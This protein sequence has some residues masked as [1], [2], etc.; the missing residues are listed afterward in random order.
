MLTRKFHRFKFGTHRRNFIEI[1]NTHYKI[2]GTPNSPVLLFSNSLGTDM[3]MW[4]EVVP[5]LL[6]YFQIVRY[7]TRGLGKSDVTD[8]P[9]TIAQLGQD[10]IDLIDLLGIDKIHFCGLSMGGQI[11]QWLGIHHSHRI[12]KLV[13]SNTGAKIGSAQGWNDR[14]ELINQK[15]LSAIWEGTKNVWFRDVFLKHNP[16]K[17]GVL[18]KMFLH[19]EVVGYA[20]CCAAVR[21][22]DFRSDIEKIKPE[23]LVITGHED[24]ATTVADAEFIV[25]KIP[26]A[27]LV[28]LAAKHIPSIEQPKLFAEAVINFLVGAT[29]QERGMHVRRTVLGNEHVDRASKNVN[30]L[31]DDFQAFISHYAW[32]EI[33]TRPGLSKH[34]RSLITLA[35]MIALNRGPE[36]KMHVKAAIHNGVSV[37]EIKEVI[38]QSGIYCG[39]PAANDAYHLAQ[40]VFKEIDIII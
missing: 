4:D 30:A 1:M 21:D 20:N 17:L 28:V 23:T 31:T 11:G 33:W 22:A 6:P 7:D 39:L 37:D 26:T 3:T 35:M 18:E 27:Q 14:I 29:T 24:P 25:E 19:N 8:E 36:F 32:G 5:L 34:H 9:Y 10:V 2:E 13:L 12:N 40:E 16:D 38:L 15:G